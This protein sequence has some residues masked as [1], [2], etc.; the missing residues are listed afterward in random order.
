MRIAVNA[1]FLQKDRMEGYGWFVQ[2]V[3]SRLANQHPEHEFLLVF[4]R[5]YDPQFLFAPNCKAIV[6]GPPARH[7]GAFLYWY[8][9][10]APAAL[11][12]FQ[13]DIW[14]QPYGFCSTTSS[15]PQLLVLHDLAFL[16]YPKSIA[17]HQLL[18]YKLFTPKFLQKAKKILTVSAFSKKDIIANYHL[19]DNKIEVVHG[20]AREI[21]Q[22]K[23]PRPHMPMVGNTF[24]SWAAS[25]P[26]K[27]Y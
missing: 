11:R 25:S 24:Y 6:V 17:W 22:P 12:K 27:T 4:D 7:V 14:V 8:N 13:P 2:E 5:P 15:I 26:A 21:F 18:Y 10:A 20:A 3:F 23:E 1:I 19:E 9:I 16:H